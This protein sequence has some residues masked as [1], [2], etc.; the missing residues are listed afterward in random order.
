MDKD[1]ILFCCIVIGFIAFIFLCIYVPYRNYKGG[2]VAR[3]IR[4]KNAQ[5][6][7]ATIVGSLEHINGLPVAKGVE[8]DVYYA[9]EKIIFKKDGQEIVISKSKITS[10]DRISK[11]FT[12]R[13]GHRIPKTVID[14]SYINNGKNKHITLDASLDS[15]FA[16][17]IEKEFHKNNYNSSTIEL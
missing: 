10:I 2:P 11:G 5:R 14:I 13:V 12:K 6:F 4:N 8:L 17:K 16:L 7:G 15:L 9:P 1:F 3:K